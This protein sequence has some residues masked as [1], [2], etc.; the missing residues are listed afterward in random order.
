MARDQKTTAD[1]QPIWFV[2]MSD[3]QKF[4][5]CGPK[6]DIRRE[7]NETAELKDKSAPDT[8]DRH[9]VTRIVAIK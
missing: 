7:F 4:R 8:S 6:E 5:A 2:Y 1:G 3:G 9:R